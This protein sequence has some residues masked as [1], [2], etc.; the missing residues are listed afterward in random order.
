MYKL[1]KLY[2]RVTASSEGFL[3]VQ[4]L[5][6]HPKD[7]YRFFNRDSELA[8]QFGTGQRWWCT[9]RP[10]QGQITNYYIQINEIQKNIDE[11]TYIFQKVIFS[12]VKNI[13]NVIL[14]MKNITFWLTFAFSISFCLTS[15]LQTLV[16][17]LF[18]NKNIECGYAFS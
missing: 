4:G 9:S 3:Q 6:H 11:I 16:T 14:L 12:L 13:K 2:L 5:L 18:V 17:S 8:K 1:I 10:L 15:E 7:F